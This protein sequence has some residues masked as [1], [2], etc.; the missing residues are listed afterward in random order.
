MFSNYELQQGNDWVPRL[1]ILFSKA[2]KTKTQ[3][4]ADELEKARQELY[5]CNDKPENQ[6]LFGCS[7][8]TKDEI[9]TFCNSKSDCIG[10]IKGTG[11]DRTDFIPIKKEPV[12]IPDELKGEGF[13]QSIFFKKTGT[14]NKNTIYIIIGVVVLLILLG[15][16]MFFKKRS[17]QDYQMYQDYQQPQDYSAEYTTQ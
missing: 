2:F 9:E 5:E 8:K 7:F 3:P 15:F 17:N 12:K 4:P 13:G 16:F 1:L 14:M 11:N 6:T 10:Y